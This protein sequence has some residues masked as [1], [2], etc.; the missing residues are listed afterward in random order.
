VTWE[1]LAMAVWVFGICAVAITLIAVARETET[2]PASGKR[3]AL[4]LIP[5]AIVLL[6]GA[7]ATGVRPVPLAAGIFALTWTLLSGLH[8]GRIWREAGAPGRHRAFVALWIAI[9]VGVAV[10]LLTIPEA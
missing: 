2:V 10:M 6:L 7:S 5:A 4:M 3:I 1:Y 9:T 8:P